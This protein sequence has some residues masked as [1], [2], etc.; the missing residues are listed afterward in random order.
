MAATAAPARRYTIDDLEQFPDDGKRR[1]LVAGQIVEWDVTSVEHG[2][3]AAVLARIIGLFVVQHRLGIVATNDA[4]VRI[5]GSEAD[6]RGVDVAFFARGRIP[7][8]RRAAA[9]SIAPDLVIEILSPSDR[10][11][12]VQQKTRDWLQAG[13]RLLWY[14]DP[15]TGITA[16]HQGERTAYV[17]TDDTLSGGEVLPGFTLRLRDIFD[18]LAALEALDEPGTIEG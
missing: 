3:I 6:T 12:P 11:G 7:R 17:D 8:D 5:Q 4:L 10:A 2:Y 18:V 15:E 1:E 9:T 13:V 14:I 16:V